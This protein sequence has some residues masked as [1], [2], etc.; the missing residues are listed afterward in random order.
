MAGELSVRYNEQYMNNVFCQATFRRAKGAVK[1]HTQYDVRTSIT[2]FLHIIPGSVHDTQAIDELT[3][4]P[5]IVKNT[6]PG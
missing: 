2:V 1:L 6:V 4:E 5:G 3:Y